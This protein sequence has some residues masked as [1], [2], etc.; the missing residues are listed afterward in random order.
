MYKNY[1]FQNFKKAVDGKFYNIFL[2][3][4]MWAKILD[5]A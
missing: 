5:W 3:F 4:L 1:K 2:L